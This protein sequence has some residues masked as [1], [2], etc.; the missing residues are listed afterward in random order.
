[1]ASKMFV[2]LDLVHEAYGLDVISASPMFF[3]RYCEIYATHPPRKRE[4]KEFQKK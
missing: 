4:E 3:G 2:N 1:M